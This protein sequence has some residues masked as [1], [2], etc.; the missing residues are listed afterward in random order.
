MQYIGHSKPKLLIADEGK[1][2]RNINDL[3]I[4]AEYDEEGNL[5]KEE[6]LPYYSTIIFL[7]EQI[8]SLE[9]CQELYIEEEE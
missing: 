6:H 3:Y 2:I 4:P 9:K 8:D 5:I 1:K 7:A